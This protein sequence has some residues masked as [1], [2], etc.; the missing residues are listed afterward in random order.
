MQEITQ[1]FIFAAG[2]GE[3]MRPLT[4]S[5]PKPLVKIKNK[6]IIDYSIEKLNK[7]SAIQKIIVNGF[8]LAKDLEDH[9]LKLNNSKIIFSHEVSK[10]E[11]GGGLAYAAKNKKFDIERPIL[12]I[13]GDILWQDQNNQSDIEKIC[14]AYNPNDC[15]ILLG[16]KKL[17]QVSGYEGQGDFDF[18]EKTGDLFKK[19]NHSQSHVFV[20]VQVVNPMILKEVK[21]ECFSMSYFYKKAVGDKGK[22]N[23]IKG[24]ELS[25]KY[26]HIGDI[27]AIASTE[28]QM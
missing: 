21:E 4:D 12:L 5:V 25:G 15:D 23:K 1:S 27:K 6:A 28:A 20:G 17:N 11:T 14:H 2:R 19:P 24:L 26:F 10:M 16:L 22:L 18:D 3:R 13:N 7:I 8:Y 9:L